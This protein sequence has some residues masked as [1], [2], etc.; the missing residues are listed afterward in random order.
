MRI[1]PTFTAV[2]CLAITGAAVAIALQPESMKPMQPATSS[3]KWNIVDTANA[4]GNFKTLTAALQAAGWA[5]QLKGPGPFTVFAP[6]DEAFAK[7]PPGTVESW[8]KPENK[9]KLAAVLTYHVVKGSVMADK[10]M[11]MSSA[12]TVN[13]QRARVTVKGNTV[14]IDKATVTRADIACT[15]GVIHVIDTVL[16]PESRDIIELA[17]S[18]GSYNTLIAA[19]KAAGWD[20]ALKGKGPFTVFAPTDEAFAKLPPGTVESWL[21][22]EN[23]DKLVAVLKYHVVQG[24]IYSDSAVSTGMAKTLEG[25]SVTIKSDMGRVWIDKAGVVTPD[26]DAANGVIHS[27]DTVLMPAMK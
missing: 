2:A 15:N 10:V 22:P 16:M 12:P 24:R 5:E 23:K 20:E 4:A 8:L 7:L 26:M 19:L 25:H 18:A 27:I 14:W 3:A 11:G 9:D 17:S 21:K 13:G 1:C 6:T